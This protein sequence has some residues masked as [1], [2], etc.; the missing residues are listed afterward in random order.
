MVYP[1]FFIYLCRQSD[2]GVTDHASHLCARSKS[3][4][5]E[6]LQCRKG[7][8][9]DKK[10]I[11]MTVMRCLGR[12]MG[13]PGFAV[14]TPQLR[15]WLQQQFSIIQMLKYVFM[16]LSLDCPLQNLLLYWTDFWANLF[17]EQPPDHLQPFSVSV[18]SVSLVKNIYIYMLNGSVPLFINC[19]WGCTST[20]LIKL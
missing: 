18:L 20:S 8:A 2:E 1:T 15:P 16:S 4:Q 5:V 19:S 3:A 10:Q 11:A 14:A 9:W 13:W 12:P 6:T 7:S 17:M